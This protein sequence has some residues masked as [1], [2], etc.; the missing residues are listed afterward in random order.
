MLSTCNFLNETFVQY[1]VL[2]YLKL[3]QGH[4]TILYFMYVVCIC[5]Y[6]HKKEYLI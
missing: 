2:L 5:Y 4:A 6:L 3:Y 1:D